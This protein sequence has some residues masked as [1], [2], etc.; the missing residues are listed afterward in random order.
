MKFTQ[1]LSDKLLFKNAADWL[2]IAAIK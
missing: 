1:A 2:G